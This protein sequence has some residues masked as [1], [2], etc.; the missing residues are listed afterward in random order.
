MIFE[1]ELMNNK[2]CEQAPVIF[3]K[4]WALLNENYVEYNAYNAQLCI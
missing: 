3:N 4:P 1:D 2:T